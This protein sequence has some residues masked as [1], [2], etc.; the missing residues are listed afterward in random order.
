[1]KKKTA[2]ILCGTVI[3]GVL[4]FFIYQRYNGNQMDKATTHINQIQQ[5]RGQQTHEETAPDP[6]TKL[7]IEQLM[8][9]AEE[10][11]KDLEQRRIEAEAGD[12]RM[13]YSATFDAA[14]ETLD[15][16]DALKES[17]TPAQ[18]NQLQDLHKRIED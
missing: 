11:A 13:G 4:A 2:Y 15:D 3:A 14:L 6:E 16:L 1:M 8:V 9:Q 18:L 10:L 12:Q 5:A 7:K 17:M